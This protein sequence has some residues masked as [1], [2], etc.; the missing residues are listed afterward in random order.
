MW[1]LPALDL[2]PW[3]AKNVCPSRAIHPGANG[4]DI[5]RVERFSIGSLYPHPYDEVDGLW[6]GW[7]PD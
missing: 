6:D 2:D 1:D 7:R 3:N 5:P 4:V